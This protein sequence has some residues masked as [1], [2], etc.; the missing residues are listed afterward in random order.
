MP[1]AEGVLPD[2]L[3]RD[4]IRCGWVLAAD[5]AIPGPNIQPASLDLRLGNVAYRL[6]SSFL[7]GDK[8]VSRSLKDHQLGP[9]IPLDNG[10]VLE[11]NRPYLIP[12]MESLKL[13]SGIKAK[14]NPK[15]ST[16]RLDIF[17]RIIVDKSPGFDEIPVGYC[18]PMYLEVVSR[19]FTIQVKDNLS[20]NQ[21][22]LIHGTSVVPD[23]ELKRMH[24]QSPLLYY[25][26]LDGKQPR[27]V[28]NLNPGDGLFLTV[29]LLGNADEIVGYRAKKNSQLLDLSQ[30]GGYLREDFWEHVETDRGKRLILEPEEFYLLVSREGVAVPPQYAGEMTAYDPTSGELRTHYAGFF[31][32]GFGFSEPNGLL[33]SR[34]VLE[35]RAH[36][37]PFALENGQ[38]IARLRYESM[39]KPPEH[40]YGPEIGSSYQ[41]QR[42]KLSK[43]FREPLLKTSHQASYL[44]SMARQDRL[45]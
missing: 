9:D 10:A 13:P 7:P 43:L 44:E 3:L 37:V 22:R 38:R 39:V 6:R 40:L 5:G 12:L 45:R 8:V 23:Q 4:A 19:S 26:G 18:G 42:L 25:Y 17:T 16:G 21:I 36:D 11:R 15:S 41:N 32:P 31:D 27:A 35:V 30:V 1:P 29:D 2:T 24:A 34:A 28:D 20:L 33:G 14:A